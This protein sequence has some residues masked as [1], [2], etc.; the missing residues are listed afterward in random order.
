MPEKW[1]RQLT[2]NSSAALCVQYRILEEARCAW[3]GKEGPE[4]VTQK[5]PFRVGPVLAIN[6]TLRE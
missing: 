3:R 6:G 1:I 5:A 4:P 2:L